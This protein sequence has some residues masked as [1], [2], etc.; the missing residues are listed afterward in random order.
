MWTIDQRLR[1]ISSAAKRALAV[2]IEQTQSKRASSS[3]LRIRAIEREH[4]SVLSK[5]R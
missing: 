3:S 1:V 5:D 4:L 2:E